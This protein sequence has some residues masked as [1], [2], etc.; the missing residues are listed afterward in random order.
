MCYVQYI[1]LHLPRF[2]N[3]LRIVKNDSINTEIYIC[4]ATPRAQEI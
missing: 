4:Y 2:H 1:Y 3:L